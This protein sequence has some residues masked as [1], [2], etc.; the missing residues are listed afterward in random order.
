MKNV[1]DYDALKKGYESAQKDAQVLADQ[2]QKKFFNNF[3]HVGSLL[4]AFIP[5]E[6]IDPSEQKQTAKY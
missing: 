1:V 2:F 3:A 6:R 5:K 4:S